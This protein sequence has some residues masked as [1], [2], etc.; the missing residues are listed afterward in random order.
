MS[1]GRDFLARLRCAAEGLAVALRRE[2]SLRTQA[3]G[4]VF[5]L[6][7]LAA[8]RP[9]SV[10]CALAAVAVG[11]VMA[12]ELLNTALEI[13]ADRL[14]PELHPEIRAAKDVAAAAVLVAAI[15]ALAVAVAF[16]VR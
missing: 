13:L 7:V 11:G 5:V 12:A 1:K 2:R 15:S 3:A 8:V 6:V 4:A 16:A 10:W 14:H 9:A